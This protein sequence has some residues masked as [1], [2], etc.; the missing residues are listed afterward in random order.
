MMILFKYQHALVLFSV[1]KLGSDKIYQKSLFRN[2]LGHTILFLE[3]Q[4]DHCNLVG[5]ILDHQVSQQ[6]KVNVAE[7]QTQPLVIVR[8]GLDINTLCCSI[9]KCFLCS[10]FSLTEVD[11][12]LKIKFHQLKTGNYV[13]LLFYKFCNFRF[14]LF[15]KKVICYSVGVLSCSSKID[16]SFIK[17]TLFR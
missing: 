1:K 6:S 3:F 4:Q 9:R 8:V 17:F 13:V 11:L 16:F 12:F 14:S 5:L 7:I 10:I 15:Y 2:D